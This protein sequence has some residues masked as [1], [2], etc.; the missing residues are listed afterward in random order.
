MSQ[1]LHAN[2]FVCVR[3]REAEDWPERDHHDRRPRAVRGEVAGLPVLEGG[4]RPFAAQEPD[5][6]PRRA[7]ELYEQE[8]VQAESRKLVRARAELGDPCLLYTS[9]SPRDRT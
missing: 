5:G 1:H 6:C 2:R 9:P 8:Q 4:E 7:E 3:L